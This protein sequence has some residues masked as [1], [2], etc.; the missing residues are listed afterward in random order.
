M[1]INQVLLGNLEGKWYLGIHDEQISPPL[2]DM[3]NKLINESSILREQPKFDKTQVVCHQHMGFSIENFYRVCAKIVFNFLAFSHG[4][5]F[6]LQEKFDPIRHWISNGGDNKFINL[7]DKKDEDKK[8]FEY[9]SF[10]DQAHTIII[11]KVNNSLIGIIGLYGGA[12]ESI[13]LLCDDFTESLNVDG[14]ICDWYNKREYTLMEY[15]KTL[16]I[17]NF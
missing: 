6:V 17:R 10:P 7:L 8:M 16:Q 15:I 2:A 14:Y 11:T 13:V 3:I 12:F 1:P 9:I 4:S 5:D